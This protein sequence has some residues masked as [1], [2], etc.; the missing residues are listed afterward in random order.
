M[1][2]PP[3]RPERSPVTTDDIARAVRAATA[4]LHAHPEDGRVADRAASVVLEQGLRCRATD[5]WVTPS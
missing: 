3:A 2:V 5:P 4:H 1:S